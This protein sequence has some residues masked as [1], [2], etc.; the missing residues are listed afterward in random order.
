M[1]ISYLDNLLLFHDL[2]FIYYAVL[3]V[4]IA[5]SSI[6]YIDIKWFLFILQHTCKSYFAIIFL[7][8][9]CVYLKQNW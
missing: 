7:H 8:M 6:L 9:F 4:F 5:S 2:L 1:S 3:I